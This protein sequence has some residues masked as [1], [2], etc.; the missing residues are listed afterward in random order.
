MILLN[1]WSSVVMLTNSLITEIYQAGIGTPVL[2]DWDAHA[3]IEELPNADLIGPAALGFSEQDQIIEASFA[4]AVSSYGTDENLFRH[5]E[6]MA[7]VFERVRPLKTFPYYQ[8]GSN[9]V[10][11]GTIVSQDGTAT[12]P[13][14]RAEV[15]P[16]QF[17]Q[18]N[19]LI[20]PTAT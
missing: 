20:D 10:V 19:C 12:V 13:L 15:R 14:S 4:I 3:N 7:R 2:C 18:V 11:L 1:L 8:A 5:R 17:V 6:M 16:Y 9:N